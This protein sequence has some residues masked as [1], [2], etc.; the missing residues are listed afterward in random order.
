LVI[1]ADVTPSQTWLYSLLPLAIV[2]VIVLGFI[3]LI[4]L[5]LL[6]GR[7]VTMT[8][9]TGGAIALTLASIILLSGLWCM[10]LSPTMTYS[11]TEDRFDRHLT[12]GGQQSW[13]YSINIQVDDTLVI[14]A[15]GI[16]AYNDS[17]K[18]LNVYL[19]DPDDD[20]LWSETNATYA[21]FS[22][23]G[24]KSGPHRIEVQNLNPNIV[25]CYMQV[26]L[27]A[28]VAYR[29]LE[30]LGQWLSL[31]SLPIFGLGMWA[32]GLFVVTRKHSYSEQQNQ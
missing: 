14:S 6:I 20:I 2:G 19:Y 3:F 15:D 5:G 28:E 23:R 8:M 21:Y 25:E 13:S 1:P 4:V 27:S 10:L 30:P 29:P 31:V 11:E 7:R 17:G 26:I 24:L 9:R 12:I 32:S 16:R 18:I 22:M